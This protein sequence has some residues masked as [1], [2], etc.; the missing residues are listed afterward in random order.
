MRKIFENIFTVIVT[1]IW[2]LFQIGV[3]VLFLLVAACIANDF[4]G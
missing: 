4:G 2:F 3:W 1:A